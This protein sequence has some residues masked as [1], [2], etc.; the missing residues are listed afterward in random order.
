MLE[1]KTE[2]NTPPSNEVTQPKESNTH[3]AIPALPQPETPVQN[4]Q[5]QTPPTAEDIQKTNLQ[6]EQQ[7][8]IPEPMDSS[9]AAAPQVPTNDVEMEIRQPSPA[10][11]LPQK[12]EQ[13]KENPKENNTEV[14]TE[15]GKSK[16]EPPPVPAKPG[17]S[18]KKAKK[19]KKQPEP[20]SETAIPLPAPGQS[21]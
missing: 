19:T 8:Q 10:K 16:K 14:A 2:E 6:E 18:P 20:V 13:P 9:S 1:I 17:K 7:Q 5:Q 4:L 3:E 12:P 15:K 11:E 21:I